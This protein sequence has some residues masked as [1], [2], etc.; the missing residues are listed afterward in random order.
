MTINDREKLMIINMA[1]MDVIC[2]NV[3]EDLPYKNPI[4]LVKITVLT[5]VGCCCQQITKN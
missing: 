2:I 1:R 5:Q 4:I 3:Y